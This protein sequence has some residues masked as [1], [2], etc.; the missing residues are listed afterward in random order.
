MSVFRNVNIGNYKILA[1]LC[2]TL[3]LNACL[4]MSYVYL[5]RMF[6][7]DASLPMSYG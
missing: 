4:P 2:Y 7:V 3:A 1:C 6:T 5:C